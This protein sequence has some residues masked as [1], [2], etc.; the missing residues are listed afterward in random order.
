MLHADRNILKE[1]LPRIAG[2]GEEYTRMREVDDVE[3]KI[4]RRL[5]FQAGIGLS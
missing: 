3:R 2:C 5:G 4:N 1:C